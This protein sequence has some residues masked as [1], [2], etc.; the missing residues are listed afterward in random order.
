MRTKSGNQSKSN[1]FGLR[2]ARIGSQTLFLGLF[3][4]LFVKTDY[5]GSD[6]IEYA[7]NIIFRLD[8]L[9]AICTILA[10]KIVIALMAPALITLLASLVFGRAFCG[11]FCPV[12]TMLDGAR[13][14]GIRSITKNRQTR[15][16]HLALLILL[17]VVVS[18]LLNFPVAGYLD[19]FSILVRALAQS[20]YP[21]INALMVSF[22]SFTYASAPPS[23]NLVT[24][25]LYSFLKLTV[26]PFDQKHF[27][28][29]LLSFMMFA[30]L[31]FLELV[32]RRFFCRNICPL[33]ALI[34]LVSRLSILQVNGGDVD[35]GKCHHCVKICRMGAIDD[36][37]NIRMGSC[38]LC[39]DCF[40]QC[41]RQIIDFKRKKFSSGNHE[42]SLSRRK[43]IGTLAVGAM[44]PPILK[45]RTTD[46]LAQA[47]LV[48]PPGAREE[49]DFISRC[50]RCAECI[51]VCIGNALQ[52]TF[53]Q[54][55]IEGIF[56]P[57]LVARS[58]Y[59]EFNCTL[60]GQVCPTGAIMELTLEQKHKT[61]I[62][63]AWFDKDICLPYAKGIPCI[64]CEEHCPT[65]DKAIRFRMA[66]VHDDQGRK[67]RVKQ[68]YVVDSLCIGCGICETKCP[69]PGRAAIYITSAGEHR[70]EDNIL[71]VS[72]EQQ[73]GSSPY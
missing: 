32:H 15:Y 69:V 8:P 6:T 41:P 34:G 33:G 29:A 56:T 52:P 55:G 54:S 42:I 67:I 21:A 19:P 26:L 40:E 30:S 64:V 59:C 11:W 2:V 31:F 44:V 65:P 9:L 22:F 47:N 72:G 57:R 71:P 43:F 49:H 50:V 45:A 51:Q 46:H 5:T 12:G 63:H 68:P 62:G 4:F 48:R 10:G 27:D 39:M 14:L 16:P 23:V 7:V 13:H 17:F 1:Y 60:C 28:L 38:S 3:F 58:G 37:R 18:S 70:D 24:E 36:T 35:C 25:P 61:K 66:D 20:L 53:L 73:S